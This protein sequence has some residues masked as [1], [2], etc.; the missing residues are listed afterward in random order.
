MVLEHV[1][2]L[3]H[4]VG[5]MSLPRGVDRDD[6]LGWGMLGLIAAAEGFDASRG[7][8]F[9]TYAYSRI[10]GAILDELRRTDALP[11]AQ[12]ALLRNVE[13]A[14]AQL[15]QEY[16]APPTPEEIAERA[17]ISTDEVVEVL[18][19]ARAAI[20]MSLEEESPG[21]NLSAMLTDPRSDDPVASAQWQEMKALLA[22]AIQRLPEPERNVILLYYGEELLLRDIGE[23]LGVTESRVSQIHSSA[24]YRLNRELALATGGSPR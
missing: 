22:Q 2:L 19:L 24:I 12:R 8:A 21:G 11:R 14:T 18:A 9:S 5:R 10:R 4:I 17:G 20:E 7:L 15:T 16:G 3:R 13:R 1:P 6:V 23:V